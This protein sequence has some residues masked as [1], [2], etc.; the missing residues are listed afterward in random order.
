MNFFDEFVIP[1]SANHVLLVKYMLII[2]LLLFIPYVCMMLGASFI[3]TYYNKKGKT[4]GNSLYSRFA[5]DIIEKLSISPNAELALGSIPAISAFF[6]YAQLLYTAKTI[7]MSMMA[8]AVILFIV[9][10]VFI[11]KYRNTFKLGSIL[12][13]LK[14]IAGEDALAST[15]ENIKHVE[16]FEESV[17]SS[18]SSTGNAG[19]WLLL[20]AT[21]IF[22]GTTALASSPEKWESVGNILQVIFSW[23]TIF[24]FLAF[25]S[26]AG[27][28]SGGA[29]MF[30]F[31][32]WNGGLEDMTDE[33]ASLIKNS[34]GTVA[35]WS[36]IL[37]PLFLLISYAYLPAAA[38][39]PGVF[40]YM[41]AV[42]II[43]LILGSSIYSMVKNSDTS[44]ATVVF[45][46]IIVLITFNILKDQLAFGNAIHD[47][48]IEITKIADEHEK[49]ARNKTLQTTGIDAEAIF[50]QKCSACHK[51]DQ[52][53]VGPP[54][55][56]TVPKY[57]GDVQKL[58]EYIFNPQK[59]DPA[60]PPMPNQ[61]LKKKEANAMAE[62]LI[63]QVGKK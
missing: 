22:A 18:N 11:Y 14:K 30:Y 40:Y 3:S 58:G 15:D 41:V 38:L 45:V 52:K 60:F 49:E 16:E 37:F 25:T 59:I 42:L 47:N 12:H 24:N 33:Y 48:T 32:R 61:G 10:F 56:Q 23:Q 13:S 54:Y 35:M 29:I 6:A 63:N 57:N 4:E 19:K 50:K 51:F 2:S 8:L 21:Y 17:E 46:L 53:V 34:A 5:K 36:G 39:S 31:F 27:I 62:W 26:L 7:T 44:S 28:L 9:S 43:S 20:T 55:Q 1:A